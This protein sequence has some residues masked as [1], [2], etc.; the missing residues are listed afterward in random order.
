MRIVQFI[1]L[2]CLSYF[3]CVCMVWPYIIFSR[4]GILYVEP[5]SFFDIMSHHILEH[6]LIS[7][8]ENS[9]WSIC[10]VFWGDS[11]GLSWDI[12]IALTRFF[13]HS[14]CLWLMQYLIVLDTCL[15]FWLLNLFLQPKCGYLNSL[16]SF[17]GFVKEVGRYVGCFRW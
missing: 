10:S 11:Y 4:F 9:S 14:S 8:F 3:I 15:P 1:S 5:F 2:Q 7:W 6:Y 13:L 17:L 16:F 12:S